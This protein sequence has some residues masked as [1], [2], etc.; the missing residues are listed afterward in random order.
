[1]D[2]ASTA[3]TLLRFA[4]NCFDN[5]QLARE[6]EDEF[7]TYQLKL[8]IL[9]LRLSRWGEVARV[10]TNSNSQTTEK[11]AS[12]G[13]DGDGAEPSKNVEDILGAI[14]DTLT[15]AQRDAKKTKS[16][17]SLGGDRAL[18]PELCMPN[19][20]KKIRARLRECLRRRRVQV[21]K[22]VDSLKWVFYK[23]DHF[24]KFVTDMSALI[25]ELENLLSED[26]REKLRELS[27]EECKG[28]S[29]PNLEELKDI[30]QECDPWLEDA[31]DEKLE[32]A[33]GAGT[34]IT[35]SYNTGMV[36]GIHKGDVNGVSNGNNNKTSNFWGRR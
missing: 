33:P 7:A 9:Q 35:Q 11:D 1:M 23:R 4:I 17:L 36:T 24:Q 26:A 18:D 2:V 12:G 3:I 32:N 27:N 29:K 19:D 31:V 6:F 13:K 25:Q 15:K 30:A 16:K 21:A 20:L 8:D 22:T 5:I 14:Q 10:T 34:Y 28:I